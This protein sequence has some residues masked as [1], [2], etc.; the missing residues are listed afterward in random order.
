MRQTIGEQ[1]DKHNS[2]VLTSSFRG[3][4]LDITLFGRGNLLYESFRDERIKL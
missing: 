3:E 4:R 2:P 1:E